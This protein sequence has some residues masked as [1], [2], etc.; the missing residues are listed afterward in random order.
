MAP[1]DFVFFF[2]VFDKYY[3][4]INGCR[5]FKQKS[6]PVSPANPIIIIANEYQSRLALTVNLRVAKMNKK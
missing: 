2:F 4:P 6:H 3:N 1:S 5:D